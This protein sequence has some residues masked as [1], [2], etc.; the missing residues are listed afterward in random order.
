M[1]P[2]FYEVLCM[3]IERG[4]NSGTNRAFKHNDS[5]PKEHIDVQV[6]QAVMNEIHEWFNFGD[7]DGY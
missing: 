4:I 3:A 6:Y 1:T 2:K 7:N 5:P